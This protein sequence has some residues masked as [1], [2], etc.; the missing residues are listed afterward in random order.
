MAFDERLAERVR[1]QE[2]GRRMK[3][4]LLPGAGLLLE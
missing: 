4:W 3:G 1:S 2:I